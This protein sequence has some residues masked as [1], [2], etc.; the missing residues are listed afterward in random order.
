MDSNIY[1]YSLNITW[2]S[3]GYTISAWAKIDASPHESRYKYGL[4]YGY[5]FSLN[6]IGQNLISHPISDSVTEQLEYN[7]NT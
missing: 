5:K 1:Q 4:A 2:A 3:F 7:Q 6:K